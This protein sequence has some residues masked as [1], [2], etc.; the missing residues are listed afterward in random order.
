[1]V[2]SF[3]TR[4]SS[5]LNRIP[6]IGLLRLSFPGADPSC[7]HPRSEEH[8]SELQSHHPNSYAVFCLKKKKK[9]HARPRPPG[10]ELIFCV[11]TVQ[12]HDVSPRKIKALRHFHVT[13]FFLIKRPPPR[14]T[15]GGT[16]F[17]FPTLF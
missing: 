2:H 13:F 11:A 12:L 16:P 1:M 3:P 8:T 14:S 6:L 17:P 7:R 4:R 5:D 9:I 15:P 10:E